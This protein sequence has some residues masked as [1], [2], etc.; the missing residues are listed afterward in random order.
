MPLY[1]HLREVD[2][3]LA[4]LAVL[5]PPSRVLMADPAEFEVESALNPHMLDAS[6]A[7]KRVDRRAAREQWLAL[8]QTFERLGLEV[9]VVPALAGQ[10]DLVFCA[11][12][13][14]P[15]PSGVARDGRPRVVPSNM[16]HRERAGEVEH[17]VAR[18]RERGFA[19]ERL[20]TAER[21]E[22][23][24]DGLWHIGRRL[25]W[26]GVGPRS[27]RA[28]WGEIAERFD[29]P[30]LLLDLVDRDFY[31]LDTCLSLLAEDACLVDWSGLAPHSRELVRHFFARPIAADPREARTS[32]ACN[33]FC[34]DARHVVL[35]RGSS[36]TCAR[37][38]EHG[39]E[40]IEVDTSE[41]LKSG[42]SVFCMKLAY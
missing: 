31:H 17:V 21:L 32:F 28:A 29:V 33:A 12:Q 26:A 39:F 41:F 5:A 11:N 10:P 8:K 1:S 9:D 34:P 38:R 14:M 6:G 3:A 13:T 36:L 18:L 16:A 2:F 19:V 4:D 15:I 35:Q 42:G 40:P 30:V 23:M 24:G 37:L 27:S 7:L 25:L 22:G 20:A